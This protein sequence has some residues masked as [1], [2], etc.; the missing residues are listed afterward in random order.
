MKTTTDYL[1]EQI[2]QWKESQKGQTSGY[3]YEQSFV[4]LWQRLGKEVFQENVGE[5]PKRAHE[6]KTSNA[7]RRYYHS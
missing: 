1:A 4:E 6:K 3:E 2:T 5:L 7:V